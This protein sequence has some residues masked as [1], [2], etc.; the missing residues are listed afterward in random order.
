MKFD[1]KPV[2][3]SSALPPIVG[4]TAI[5]KTVNIE[6]MRNNERKTVQVNVEELPES[7]EI[8]STEGKSVRLVDDRLAIVVI[9]LSDEQ[10][11]ELAIPKGGVAV[12]KVDAGSAAAAGLRR[13]DVILSINSQKVTD[14]KQF[15]DIAKDLPEDKAI[16]VL[17]QRGTGSIF[18]ALR[19]KQDQE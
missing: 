18:L 19:I 3:T 15:L 1:G 10:R 2:S 7:E 6:V 11:E 17:V 4:R 12:I 5:G 8:A 16:P 13:G 14:A 9:D